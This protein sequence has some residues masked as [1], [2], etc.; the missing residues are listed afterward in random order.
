MQVRKLHL[1]HSVTTSPSYKV[2]VFLDIMGK[3][4]VCFPIQ[5]QDIFILFYIYIYIYIY[6]QNIYIYICI[7]KRADF[8]V[9]S[10][11]YSIVNLQ[12]L[13]FCAD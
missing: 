11:V 7:Y 4:H 9:S 10:I 3:V 6:I 5:T 12:F 1:T 8:E 13:N 2:L